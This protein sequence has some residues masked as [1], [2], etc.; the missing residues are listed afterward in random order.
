M[1]RLK[2]FQTW[3]ISYI[4]ATGANTHQVRNQCFQVVTDGNDSSLSTKSSGFCQK[5]RCA[6]LHLTSLDIRNY[7][8]FSHDLLFLI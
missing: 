2:Q 4:L 1:G 5:F 6:A 3:I 8:Y 7:E